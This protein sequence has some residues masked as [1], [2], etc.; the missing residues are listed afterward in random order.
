M[1]D[2]IPSPV[3]LAILQD[4]TNN[5]T[6]EQVDSAVNKY[7]TDN[8]VQAYDDSEIK[9]DI[10]ELKED[11]GELL[12]VEKD[13][14]LEVATKTSDNNYFVVANP[15][16][17]AGK[18]YNLEFIPSENFQQTGIKAGTNSAA[19]YMVDSLVD[20]VNFEGGVSYW[21][22][23]YS[24]SEDG[25]KYIRFVGN[26]DKCILNIYTPVSDGGKIEKIKNGIERLECESNERDADTKYVSGK[27]LALR[28]DIR[29]IQNVLDDSV[30]SLMQVR[31]T[32]G[33]EKSFTTHVSKGTNIIRVGLHYGS[34]RF[35]PSDNELFFDGETEKDFS[36]VRFFANGN[37]LKAKFGKAVNL[38]LLEDNYLKKV[39]KIS[40]NGL[41][42]A[43]DKKN[44]ILVSNDNARTYT[45]IAGT[46]NITT[47][48]SAEYKYT[49]MCP[50]FI[51]DSDNIYAYA[52]GKLYKLIAPTYAEKRMVLD[53]SWVDGGTTIYP[54][55]QLHGMDKATD[56]TLFVGAC[57]QAQRHTEIY[58]SHDDGETWTSSWSLYG[59]YAQ[60]VHHIHADPHSNDVYVGVDDGGTTFNGA[61]IL[62]TS[63]GGNTWV[64][65][66]DN[67]HFTR[68]RDYY[69]TYF[70]S[71]FKLGGGES[72]FLGG[73]T[74]LRGNADDTEYTFPVKGFA[75]VRSYAGFGSDD[76][77]ICG[78]QQ[79]TGNNV[80]Q[81]FISTDKG[82][83][84]DSIYKKQTTFK[85]S[86]GV[87]FRQCYYTEPTND[88]PCVVLLCDDGDVKPIRVY[89]GGDNYYREAFVLIES[90]ED[91]DVTITA[92]TGYMMAYPY[93]NLNDK[94][95]DGLIYE[96]PLSEG[97]GRYVSD[98]VGNVVG[99]DG[100]EYEWDSEEPVRYDD[101]SGNSTLHPLTPSSGLKL[102][103]NSKLNFGKIKNLDFSKN[104]TVTFWVNPKAAWLT[105]DGYSKRASTVNTFFRIG[106]ISF[107]N[108]Q[109]YF[110]YTD[111]PDS[112]DNS[113]RSLMSIATNSYGYSDQY[114]FIAISVDDSGHVR[115]Y[116]NGGNLSPT[117][118]EE[119]FT[120]NKLSDGDFEVVNSN[121]FIS[122]IKVYNRVIDDTEIMEI[123]K[124]I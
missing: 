41:F 17:E 108:R 85:K 61:H 28:E 66:T 42:V 3:L 47:H 68:G 57:Y 116:V 31:V 11:L 86:S 88:E 99:I 81:I 49:S 78:S 123:Y 113:N 46:G 23:N 38:E 119:L 53:Y 102:G 43:F 69:P 95:H 114:F 52:E 59:D 54:D 37:M 70:G 44:G 105:Q 27:L 110:G 64:D 89:K 34:Q 80:N 84:W 117:V 122:D 22:R 90:D 48:P 112:L 107:V 96:I 118:S 73:G 2:L 40:K 18:I 30:S 101:Y 92:K 39:V 29:R 104:Y 20:S 103:V 77:I 58:V 74:I 67:N 98:S 115:T 76:F 91:A 93:K 62:K 16:M 121:G 79:A 72:Y 71:D 12:G 7:L 56:G 6:D 14:L 50:I 4:K 82:I 15:A 94:E 87:G 111:N 1:S 51:D 26:T 45:T 10:G 100:D 124:G 60:H 24:P 8:P 36:D 32:N 120:L 65:I 19:S 35:N 97:V 106:D 63:D 75:G 9:S 109:Y 55:I 33:A 83:T 13:V 25:L 21:I 5:V